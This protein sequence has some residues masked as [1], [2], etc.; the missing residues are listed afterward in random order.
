M[1]KESTCNEGDTGDW[2]LIP[3]LGKTPRGRKW[4]S[5]PVFLPENSHER[6]SLADYSLWGR[7]ESD[8]TEQLTH[9]YFKNLHCTQINAHSPHG[10]NWTRTPHVGCWGVWLGSRMSSR[11]AAAMTLCLTVSGHSIQNRTFLSFF[12]FPIGKVICTW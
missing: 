10:L 11:A 8:M 2:S 4:Q 7:K 5:T 9:A 6:R 3:G 12:F 1:G